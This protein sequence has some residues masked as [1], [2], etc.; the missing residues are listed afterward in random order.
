MKTRWLLCLILLGLIVVLPAIVQAA[1]NYT[2]KFSNNESVIINQS[3]VQDPTGG[4]GE[5]WILWILSGITG[6]VL[7]IIALMK[8]RLQRM[9]YEVNIVISVLA[10]PFVWYW[11]WGGLT[12]ID[13]IVGVSMASVGG[14]SV[15]IT[16]HIYY[17]Y[18][19][20]GWIG[21]GICIA[22]VF[23]TILL[24]GA[25]RLFKE[26]DEDQKKRVALQ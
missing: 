15:M 5:P 14:K 3:F 12:S 6:L 24:I 9:D 19:I 11:T 16:Q 26:N 20:L 1:E 4:K 18:P 10:W 22:S 8:P 7:I 13:Y 21:V 17:T 25:F 2:N 23:V